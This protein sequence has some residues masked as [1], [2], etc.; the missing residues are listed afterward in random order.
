MG[1]KTFMMIQE[2][3]WVEY[4]GQPWYVEKVDTKDD[5]I[6]L[7]AHL[8]PKFTDDTQAQ[9]SYNENK[10]LPEV[11]APKFNIGET[12]IYIG[13]TY[14][15]YGL[16]TNSQVKIINVESGKYPYE[17]ETKTKQHTYVSPYEIIRIEL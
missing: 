10:N 6:L 14:T 12:I 13:P 3:I 11:Q 9:V 16:Y 1:D 17:V 8:S 2:D 5:I 15:D 4:Q 7:S